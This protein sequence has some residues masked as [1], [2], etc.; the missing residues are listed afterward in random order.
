MKL[1][2]TKGEILHIDNPSSIT[3]H[4][5]RLLKLREPIAASEY[6]SA[7]DYLGNVITLCAGTTRRAKKNVVFGKSSFFN[8]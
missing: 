6:F 7:S 8:L 2:T 4:L 3:C 1:L 5:I